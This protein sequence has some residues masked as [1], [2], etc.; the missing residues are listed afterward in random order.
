MVM[1]ILWNL[2]VDSPE[3]S[4]FLVSLMSPVLNPCLTTVFP[5]RYSKLGYSHPAS[6]EGHGRVDAAPMGLLHWL[7]SN[8][9]QC[10]RRAG[11][12]STKAPRPCPP[13]PI[14]VLRHHALSLSVR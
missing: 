5:L 13:I 14:S 3:Q 7:R 8:R 12:M 9:P 6:V 1:S 11:I 10:R 4:R 2:V